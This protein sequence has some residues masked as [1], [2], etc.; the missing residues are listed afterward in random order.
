MIAGP[1]RR[2]PSLVLILGVFCSFF[3]LFA[4]DPQI[5]DLLFSSFLFP[6]VGPEVR[7]ARFVSFFAGCFV[8]V[9]FFLFASDPRLADL[10]FFSFP[11]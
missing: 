9:L 7:P 4:S 1:V 2:A 10:F 11:F 8:F 5:T 3:P 6:F